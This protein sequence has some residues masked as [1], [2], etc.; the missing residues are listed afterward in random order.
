MF[1]SNAWGN[2]I[3]FGEHF[4][5][6]GWF[7]HRQVCNWYNLVDVLP[8]TVFFLQNG[9]QPLT[10][11]H[12][13][14]IAH[15]S[16]GCAFVRYYLIFPEMTQSNFPLTFCHQVIFVPFL[17]LVVV[18]SPFSKENLHHWW[19]EIEGVSLRDDQGCRQMGDLTLGK[20]FQNDIK[21]GF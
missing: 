13:L 11:N 7:N 4:L 10:P 2:R 17:F 19:Q 3:H 14:T 12:Q 8:C 9:C 18:S 15:L 20:P 16:K 6:M 5:K 1:T 21:S